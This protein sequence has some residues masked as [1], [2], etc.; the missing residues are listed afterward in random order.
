MVTFDHSL[1][2]KLLGGLVCLMRSRKIKVIL[3]TS[4]APS[5]TRMT[6]MMMG[7]VNG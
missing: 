4:H 6:M 2:N 7:S 3:K 1:Q 5:A